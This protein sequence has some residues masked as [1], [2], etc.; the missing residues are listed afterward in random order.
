M[1]KVGKILNEK[2]KRILIVTNEDYE[3]INILKCL[4]QGESRENFEIWS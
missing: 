3:R 1:M 2:R 4:E